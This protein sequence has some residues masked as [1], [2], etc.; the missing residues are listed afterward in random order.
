MPRQVGN[1]PQPAFFQ[2]PGR[3]RDDRRNKRLRRL[4]GV[5]EH[6]LAIT[7]GQWGQARGEIRLGHGEAEPRAGAIV[8]LGHALA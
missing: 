7:L 6:D 5:I 2:I 8:R 4:R 1:Q 3:H